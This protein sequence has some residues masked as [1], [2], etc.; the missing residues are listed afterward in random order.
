MGSVSSPATDTPRPRNVRVARGP[1][2]AQRG[3]T[4][5]VIECVDETC[6]VVGV[7]F[8]LSCD[9]IQHAKQVVEDMAP[10]VVWHET[11]PGFWVARTR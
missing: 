4:A 8:S 7:D 6:T 1:S 2:S 3:M 9:S 11:T 5:V 10:R